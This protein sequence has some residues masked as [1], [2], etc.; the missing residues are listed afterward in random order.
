MISFSISKQIKRSI[1]NLLNKNGI[2]EAIENNGK[3]KELVEGLSNID[4]LPSQDLRY[5]TFIGDF[6]QHC[7]NN[8]DW[9]YEFLFIE[10]MHILQDDS[11]FQSFIESVISP[12]VLI[13]EK[14]ITEVAGLINEEL[15]SSG[16]VLK[17]FKYNEQ[18]MPLYLLC[19]ADNLVVVKPKLKEKK[20][21][22]V[23]DNKPTGRTDRKNNHQYPQA[24][25]PCFVLVY[26]DGWNDFHVYSWYEL[27]W[28][29]ARDECEYIG[30]VK[31]IHKTQMSPEDVEL[32]GY[33]TKDYLPKM[34]NSLETDIVSLGQSYPYY[35]KLKELFPDDYE[36]VL[37]ALQDCAI[38]PHC[39]ECFRNHPQFYSLTRSNE[40]ERVMREAKFIMQDIPIYERYHFAFEFTPDYKGG[41]LSLDFAFN[42]NSDIPRRLYVIIGENGVGKTQFLAKMPIQYAKH[43]I[44]DFFPHLPIFSRVLTVSMS[45]YDDIELPTECADFT[46]AF[47]GLKMTDFLHETKKEEVLKNHLLKAIY[48]IEKRESII[49]TMSILQKIIPQYLLNKII[50]LKDNKYAFNKQNLQEVLR[51]LSSGESSLLITFC[52]VIAQLRYNTLL[53]IDEPETHL[54]PK[55]IQNMMDTIYALLEDFD[56][57]A[58]I[59]THSPLIVREALADCVYVIRRIDNVPIAGKI[60]IESFGNNI[61]ELNEEV[62]GATEERSYYHKQIAKLVYTE[63]TYEEVMEKV[64]SENVYPN[65]NLRM[66]VKNLCKQKEDA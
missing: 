60:K 41:K 47:C 24:N 23:V 46:Y 19:R 52:D 12:E 50:I 33:Y 30:A 40:A 35:N 49:Q 32:K 53:L 59:A 36:G 61:D 65:F 45:I 6:T 14:M 18:G 10:R 16:F 5:T 9:D 39:Y 7:I 54:H 34:F 55:A 27:Y 17:L 29:P 37:W 1:F 38:Y 44:K 58:I 63:H 21:L 20:F 31:I 66:F 11:V 64:K 42:G 15:S 48:E 26:N 3:L 13:H 4:I 28:H 43:E 57:Y 22:F 8:S 51:E 56:S 62:F 2:L 25:L